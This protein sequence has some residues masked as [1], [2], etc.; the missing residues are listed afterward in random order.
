MEKEFYT[1]NELA[2]ITGFTTRSLRNFI[3]M[4][5]LDGEKIDGIWQFSS[6]QIGSFIGNPNIAPGIKSKNN[7]VV[8]DFM[9][10]TNKQENQIC[11]I[12]DL[13]LSGEEVSECS[14]YFCNAMNN[15]EA[16]S[17]CRMKFEMNGENVRV[18]I[19]GPDEFVNDTI[20]GWYK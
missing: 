3:Q 18:I 19:S 1:I 4:G 2:K 20:S 7:S 13:K 11:S 9:S 8:Y 12:L 6:E 17:K 10:D 14:E 15:F 16:S 5:H